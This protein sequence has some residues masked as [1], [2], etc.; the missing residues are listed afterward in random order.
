[1]PLPDDYASEAMYAPEAWFVHDLEIF[2]DEKRIVGHVDTTRLG[3]IAEA[4]RPWPQHPRHF[5]GAVAVQITGVLGQL[6]AVYVLQL[7]ATEGW[8]GFGTHIK[9][10]RFASMG[11][12]GPPVQ[13]HLEATSVRN[14]RGTIFTKYRFRFEQEE[15]VIYNSEQ[16]AA[17]VRSDHR[18][19]LTP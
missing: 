8:V 15:R 13:A 14:I 4:Q 7:R 19:P 18:G 3:P 1:M 6:Y 17:W 12:I 5:P 2:A 16:T 9:A 10:A 11:I